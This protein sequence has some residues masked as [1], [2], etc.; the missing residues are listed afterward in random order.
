M[1]SAPEHIVWNERVS[2]C[3]KLLTNATMVAQNT[4]TAGEK[5]ITMKKMIATSDRK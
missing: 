5:P 3:R 4:E 1:V 2:T